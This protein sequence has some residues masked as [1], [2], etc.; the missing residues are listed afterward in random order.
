[1]GF[2]EDFFTVLAALATPTAE[3][4][5][6]MRVSAAERRHLLAVSS[7]LAEAFGL[8]QAPP[9]DT[10]LANVLRGTGTYQRAEALRGLVTLG[11]CTRVD[12]YKLVVEHGRLF[13]P[14]HARELRVWLCKA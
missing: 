9:E 1:M 14:S 5:A 13:P 2:G 4:L 7:V 6:E 3:E 12:A 8:P 10:D 11:G